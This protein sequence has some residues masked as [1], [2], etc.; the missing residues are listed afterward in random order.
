MR[1]KKHTKKLIAIGIISIL[2]LSIFAK[3]NKNISTFVSQITSPQEKHISKVSGACRI[4]H[5]QDFGPGNGPKWSPDDTKILYYKQNKEN[6]YQVHTIDPDG[7]NDRCLTCASIT[8]AP[9]IN[10]HKTGPV[11][12]PSGRF[13][14]LTGEMASHPLGSFNNNRL[15]TEL[16][17]NGLWSDIYAMS[18]DGKQWYKLT[19]YSSTKEDGA[20]HINI[21]PDGQK[22]AWSR[23]GQKANSNAPFGSWKLMIADFVISNNGV[24]SL[25]NIQDISPPNAHLLE[26]HGFSPDSKILLFTGDMEQT[27]KWDM[28]IWS[29][30]IF[31]G[32]ITNLT[33]GPHWEEHASY[34]SSGKKITYVSSSSDNADAFLKT[35]LF[36]MNPD[37]SD[38]KQITHFN[39]KGYLESTDKRSMVTSSDW[40]SEGEKI[41]L[42]QQLSFSY[43]STHFWILTFEDRCGM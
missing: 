10:K 6:I 32:E 26:A 30:N 3:Q 21:S 33:K 39:T 7:K 29:K 5:A 25:H 2:S 1:V 19:N 31:S 16:F 17:V 15:V 35:E 27:H 4:T 24:P 36:M 28:D 8:G 43:P 18:P 41:A 14:L 11:W 13:I 37:G 23:M 34:T 42:T 40:N 9:S 20:M 38:K 22:I 12:H